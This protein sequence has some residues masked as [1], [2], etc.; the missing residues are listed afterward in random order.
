MIPSIG[1]GENEMRKSFQPLSILL[2]LTVLMIGFSFVCKAEKID[3]TSQSYVAVGESIQEAINNATNGDIIVIQDGIHIEENY[4][5]FVNKSV[6]LIGQNVQETVIDGNGSQKGIFLTNATNARFLNLTVQNTT[7]DWFA[8]GITISNTANVEISEC[9][10]T[11]C[12]SGIL[13]SNAVNNSVIRNKIYNNRGYGIYLHAYSSSNNLIGNN[14][15]NNPTGIT[16]TDPN[17]QYNLIYYN[18]FVNNTFQQRDF[19][20]NYWNATYPVGGNYWSDHSN[21]DVKNGVDQ[22]FDGSDGIADS[23]YQG[24]DWFPLAKPIYFFY[25][26]TWNQQD[27]HVA[28]VTNSTISNLQFDPAQGNFVRFNAAGDSGNVGCCRA[29]IPKEMLW[30][31]NS[32]Q[33]SVVINETAITNLLTTEDSVN[34]YLYFTYYQSTQT[35]QIIGTHAVPEYSPFFLITAL[36]LALCTVCL[37][38]RK[39]HA[40]HKNG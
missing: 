24:L 32:G 11:S 19:A 39:L 36:L 31:D 23:A 29:A 28:T 4:P 20:S 26:Y 37:L 18:N 22:D 2:I 14:I 27:Y 7:N 40:P 35:I 9:I 6:T 10:I 12:G 3:L 21:I 25:M 16:I 15:T 5:I 33:W 30:T 13:F 38:A 1:I 17:C 8:S 34:T